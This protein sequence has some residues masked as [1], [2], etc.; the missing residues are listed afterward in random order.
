MPGNPIGQRYGI[1]APTTAETLAQWLEEA[2]PQSAWV[3]TR[4]KRPKVRRLRVRRRSVVIAFKVRDGI[5]LQATRRRAGRKHRVRVKVSAGGRV[6]NRRLRPGT[7]YV[8]RV[9]AV[10]T[11]GRR[12]PALR[13]RVHTLPAALIGR[14]RPR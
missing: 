9:V 5:E 3:F 14:S 12:S 1:R 11:A 13:L 8:Y 6:R 2:L 4:P 10:D 7:V